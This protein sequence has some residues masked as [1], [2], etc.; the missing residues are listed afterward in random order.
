MYSVQYLLRL[1]EKVWLRLNEIN[2]KIS[3]SYGNI[4][5]NMSVSLKRKDE[6]V[7]VLD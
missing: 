7:P 4:V 1:H 6:F 2:E 3:P 5:I